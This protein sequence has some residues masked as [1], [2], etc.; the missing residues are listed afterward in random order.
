MARSFR[1]GVDHQLMSDQLNQQRDPG[2]AG[3]MMIHVRWPLPNPPPPRPTN[4]EILAI[5]TEIHNSQ[6]LIIYIFYILA[7]FGVVFRTGREELIRNKHL[8]NECDWSTSGSYL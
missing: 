1:T 2:L 6:E 3:M 4:M 7:L 5:V 8:K